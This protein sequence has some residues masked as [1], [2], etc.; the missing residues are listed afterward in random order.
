M[1]PQRLKPEYLEGLFGTL[2]LRSEQALEVVPIPVKIKIK[3]KVKGSGR[4]RPLYAGYGCASGVMS[5][6]VVGG[7]DGEI[8]RRS[9][10]KI[11]RGESSVGVRFPLPAPSPILV[12]LGDGV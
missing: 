7:R 5:R 4:R 11:R 8:G 6:K 2:R 10:L 9:G 12:D 1:L 3:I